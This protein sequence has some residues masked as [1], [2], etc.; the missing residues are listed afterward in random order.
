MGKILTHCS[1]FA[2]SEADV[3]GVSGTNA[4][5]IPNLAQV[6]RQTSSK[7]MTELVYQ[8]SE[9]IYIRNKRNLFSLNSASQISAFPL[10]D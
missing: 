9:S 10:P 6:E 2:C 3:D 7:L 5:G 8:Q 4:E 1:R